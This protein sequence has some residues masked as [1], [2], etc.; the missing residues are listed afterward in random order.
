MTEQEAKLKTEIKVLKTKNVELS[1]RIRAAIHYCERAQAW[2]QFDGND[3]V[4]EVII[5]TL[6]GRIR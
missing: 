3:D 2:G 1:R 6:A 5:E 4:M